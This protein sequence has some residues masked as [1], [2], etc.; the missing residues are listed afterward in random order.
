MEPITNKKMMYELLANNKLGN[1]V[2][3]YFSYGIWRAMKPDPES[4]WGIRSLE[5][6]NDPR[7]I[8][9]IKSSD[10]LP[11]LVKH[12][13]DDEK[14]NIS[15]MVDQYSKLRCQV[16]ECPEFVLEYVDPSI[17]LIGSKHPWRTGFEKHRLEARGSAARAILRDYMNG[18]DYEYLQL[19]LDDY[20]D[21]TIEFS[22]CDREL[23]KW[24]YFNTIIWEVRKY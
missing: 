22:I 20:P 8:L 3:Q 21:H 18:I 13:K 19:L 7:S 17:S 12:F 16:M 11:Y 4:L 2:P 15:P 14:Y 10:V 24:R 5:G 1:T 6:A 23:G 9:N